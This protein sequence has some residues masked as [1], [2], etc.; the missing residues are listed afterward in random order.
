MIEW[1]EIDNRLLDPHYYTRDG[2]QDAFRQMRDD[3][4][5]RWV[6]DDRYGKHYWALTRYADVKEY[7]L[8]D[9]DFSSRWES[10]VPRSPQRLTPEQ[11]HELGFDVNITVMDDPVHDLYRRPANKHFSVPQIAK[12]RDAVSTIVD[13]ILAEVSERGAC[14]LV[15]D[16]AGELPVRVVL[17]LLGV[18]QADWAYLREASWQFLAAADPRWMIDGDPV[19]TS[20]LG[21][22]KL[23]DYGTELALDRRENPKDDFA[24]IV[25]NLEIDGDKL[26]VHEIRGWTLS[27]IAGGLET[28]RNA[29][30]VGLWKLMTLPEQRELLVSDPSVTGSAVE[31]IVRWVTPAKNRL[32]IAARDFEFRG[33]HIKRGDWVVGFLASA[34]KD[35]RI[36]DD[37]Q[38]LDIRRNPN[39]HIAFGLGPHLC[40]GRALARLELE[41]LVPRVLRAFPD[42]HPAIDGEPAWIADTSVTGFTALPVAYKPISVPS[43]R[44]T[45]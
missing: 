4:P 27:L 13:D 41:L 43:A 34:N 19:E 36:F 25:A 45:A 30:A 42:M 18:P 40:L 38:V 44:A 11:R 22:R 32:R 20:R 2:Y 9:R 15:E 37:P 8:S 12:M 7:L 6:R 3:D 31:E 33:R 28:T 21:I 23:L 1:D 5:V 26:S 17:N 14:D 29:A 10:R 35:E 39:P 16:I 24:T